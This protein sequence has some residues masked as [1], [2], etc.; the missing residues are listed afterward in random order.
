MVVEPTATLVSA[1]FITE[2]RTRFC[3]R[4]PVLLSVAFVSGCRSPFPGLLVAAITRAA[5]RGEAVVMC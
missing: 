4:P 5:I 1:D 2:M 3:M